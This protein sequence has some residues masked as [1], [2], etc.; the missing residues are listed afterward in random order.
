[1]RII[2][3][4]VSINGSLDCANA[5]RKRNISHDFFSDN[6]LITSSVNVCRHISLCEA[7]VSFLTVKTA[8]KSNTH[9]SARFVKSQEFGLEIHKSDSIS[10]KI[11][12]NDGGCFTQSCTEKQS[13]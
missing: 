6:F 8:F 7:G 3:L 4:D 11:F 5:H 9:C 12:F 2:C 1:L 13:P 10:L